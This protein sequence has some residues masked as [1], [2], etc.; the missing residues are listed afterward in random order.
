MK[1]IIFALFFLVAGCFLF[2]FA[3]TNKQ[4]AA[5]RSNKTINMMGVCSVQI[6]R[7]VY[8]QCQPDIKTADCR[9]LIGQKCPENKLRQLGK[10]RVQND[11]IQTAKSVFDTPQICLLVVGVSTRGRF[12]IKQIKFGDYVFVND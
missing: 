11:Q 1:Q 8:I 7:R 6:G 3:I 4:V 2:L 10:V 5:A 9:H 12:K